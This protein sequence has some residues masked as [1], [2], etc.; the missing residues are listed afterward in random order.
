MFRNFTYGNIRKQF[1]PSEFGVRFRKFHYVTLPEANVIIIWHSIYLTEVNTDLTNIEETKIGHLELTN[2][3]SFRSWIEAS[4]KLIFTSPC[5]FSSRKFF[6]GD[7]DDDFVIFFFVG[8]AENRW[9]K[10]FNRK[11]SVNMSR[12]GFCY[13]LNIYLLNL[14]L[15]LFDRLST[16]HHED[17]TL[18]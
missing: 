5:R 4:G 1:N 11:F 8:Q 10:N 12:P 6:I 18:P 15:G 2:F 14:E 17:S 3:I 7:A 9:D 13:C 16:C